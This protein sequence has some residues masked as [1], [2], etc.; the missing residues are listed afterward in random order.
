MCMASMCICCVSSAS[1]LTLVSVTHR[2]HMLPC[3]VAG[4]GFAYDHDACVSEA[5]C[6]KP[7]AHKA[8]AFIG[9]GP[10]NFALSGVKDYGDGG[11]EHG[12]DWITFFFQFTFA[13]AAA[14]IVSGAVAE[15]CQLIAYMVYSFGITGL[16][17][18]TLA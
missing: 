17:S 16:V 18:L 2:A 1:V 7:G 3:P 11:H 10:T 6:A 12:Y 8:N 15:R 14:T 5:D 13:A 9:T 4:Y